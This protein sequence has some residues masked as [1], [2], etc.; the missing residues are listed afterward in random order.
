LVRI[1]TVRIFHRLLKGSRWTLPALFPAEW[2]QDRKVKLDNILLC[3][4][5]VIHTPFTESSETPIQSVRSSALGHV[6]VFDEF[7]PGLLDIDEFSHILLLYQFHRADA[8]RLHVAP[9]LDDREHG[10]FASRHP[11][12][13]N[14]LGISIVQLLSIENGLLA[15]S[16]VDILNDSPLLDIKPYIP[17]FDQRQHVRTGWFDRRAKE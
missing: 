16:G 4:I 8:V 7:I 5:G 10:V 1:L 11:F 3:P 2:N 14:H 9:F 17:D 12:R 15:V 13:P 6:E